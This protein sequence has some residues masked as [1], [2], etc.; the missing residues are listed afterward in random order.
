MHVYAWRERNGSGVAAQAHTGPEARARPPSAGSGVETG[1][2]M[3][4][5]GARA[6]QDPHTI[7]GI[8]TGEDH[9]AIRAGQCNNRRPYI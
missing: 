8:L 3:E 1:E 4:R 9:R 7:V 5:D 2:W 6:R